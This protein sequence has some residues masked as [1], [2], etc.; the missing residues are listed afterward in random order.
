MRDIPADFSN[1][2]AKQTW[3]SW[4]DSRSQYHVSFQL[5]GGRC[6]ATFC[7]MGGHLGRN[8]LRTRSDDDEASLILSRPCKGSGKIDAVRRGTKP[9]C[10]RSVNGTTSRVFCIACLFT[11]FLRW[12]FCT[13]VAL[14]AFGAGVM[15][16]LYRCSVCSCCTSLERMSANQV[17]RWTPKASGLM[18]KY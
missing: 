4:L 8:Y 9:A 7:I 14:P 5:L 11:A 3:K 10:G 16:S 2:P 15:E 13:P 1:E 6:P 18:G 12:H 17:W